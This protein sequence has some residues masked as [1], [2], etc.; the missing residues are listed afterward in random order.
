MVWL[1]YPG[2]KSNKFCGMLMWWMLSLLVGIAEAEA[3]EKKN[4]KYEGLDEK[5]YLFQLIACEVQGSAGPSKEQFLKDLCKSLCINN[6]LRAGGFLKQ[7]S[8]LDI[9]I[10]NAACVQ[11]LI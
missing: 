8:S 4:D 6:E 5:N 10:A 3:E 7:R 2:N 11:N 1:L 9:Q